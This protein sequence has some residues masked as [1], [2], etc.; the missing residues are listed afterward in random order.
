MNAPMPVYNN[1]NK[2]S[3]SAVK[4]RAWVTFYF[5]ATR[6][7]EPAGL[8]QKTQESFAKKLL[9]IPAVSVYRVVPS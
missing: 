6:P 1:L 7:D 8:T 2:D 4:T 3:L 9:S 5:E